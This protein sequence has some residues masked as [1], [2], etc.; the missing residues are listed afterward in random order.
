MLG[1]L[2]EMLSEALERKMQA[3]KYRLISHACSRARCVY[4]CVSPYDHE[5]VFWLCADDA[6]VNMI[7]LYV[8][9]ALHIYTVLWGKI[10][11]SVCKCLV[12]SIADER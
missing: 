8:D 1:N 5:H 9:I 7:N 3:K 11:K 12:C 2:F 6:S 10:F 4:V